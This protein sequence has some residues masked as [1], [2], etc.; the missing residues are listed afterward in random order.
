M[1]GCEDRQRLIVRLA[2][3][4]P[5]AAT[6]EELA[7]FEAH[8]TV[9]EACRTALADQRL[10]AGLLRTRPPLQPSPA[11]AARLSS[12]LDQVSGWLGLLDWQ[13]WTFRLAPVALALFLAALFSA[14]GTSSES[15]AQATPTLET[16]AHAVPEPSSVTSALWQG[17]TSPDALQDAMLGGTQVRDTSDVR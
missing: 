6:P 17:E 14:A 15:S 9:C 5:D 12:R 7:A 16:W 13:V 4:S 2:D 11:F 1:N 10:V 8:L 3:G